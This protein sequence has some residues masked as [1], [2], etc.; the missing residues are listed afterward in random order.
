MAGRCVLKTSHRNCTGSEMYEGKTPFR[1]FPFLTYPSSIC[2][3]DHVRFFCLQMMESHVKTGHAS[4]S[5]DDILAL[6]KVLLLWMQD[7]QRVRDA[8]SYVRMALL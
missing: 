5:D 4:S 2:S 8:F 3:D 7:H 6:R 1:E